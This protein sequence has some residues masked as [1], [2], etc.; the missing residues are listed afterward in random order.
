MERAVLYLRRIVAGSPQRRPGFES[1]SGHVEFVMEKEQ[2]D[3]VFSQYFGF[4]YQSFVPLIAPSPSTIQ[5]WYNRLINDLS[6]SGLGSTP[7]KK[8]TNKIRGL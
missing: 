2:L 1:S 4:P 5:G 8:Q 7:N 3:Q 6:A